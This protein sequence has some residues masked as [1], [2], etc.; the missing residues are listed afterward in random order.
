[1]ATQVPLPNRNARLSPPQKPKPRK[2][3]APPLPDGWRGSWKTKP[4]LD[5]DKWKLGKVGKGPRKGLWVAKPIPQKPAAAATTDTPAAPEVNPYTGPDAALLWQYKDQ[6]WAQNII[7]SL[8]GEQTHHEGY[9]NTQVLPWASGALTGLA[10]INKAAQ[11]QFTGATNAAA[12]GLAQAAGATPGMVAGV[13]G[14]AV[15]SPSAFLEGASAEAMANRAS[16]M[17][18]T[19]A[20]QGLMGT[21]QP[22]TFSQGYIASLSDYA[23]GLPALYAEKRREAID[24]IDKYLA[25][26]E[27]EKQKIAIEQARF[28][29]EAARH[30]EAIRHN[31]V[32]ESISATNAQTNAA[33]QFGRL[34][35]DAS[36]AAFKMQGEPGEPM[37]TS[38]PVG[39]MVVPTADGGWK[40]VRDVTVPQ[41]TNDTGGG[42]GGGGDDPSPSRGEY[43]PN[44]LKKEGF[45]RLPKGAGKRYRDAAVKA[46][47]GTLWYKPGG[48][49]GGG[50]SS[51]SG[52]KPLSAAT[53]ISELQKLYK[54]DDIGGW[55]ERYDG[56]PK[57]AGAE[58]A[59][60]IRQNKSSF[61]KPGGGRAVDLQKLNQVLRTI[62]GQPAAYAKD[63]LLRGYM[64]AD[65][66]RW[67]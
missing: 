49:S 46:T 25:E 18:Q 57:G 17:G 24:S 67:K 32:Q 12:Q 41:A 54:K 43:P 35:I 48:K 7:R 10:N 34:G 5:P 3:K 65:G 9:V 4:K 6:P 38:A 36:T 19:A 22:T 16:T 14:G 52:T 42:G 50:K 15:A 13:S 55:E 60:W 2:P 11:D 39:W 1:M 58:I 33:I 23:K 40:Y 64:T 47:D 28:E 63:I 45:K 21:L 44:K 20:W 26:V 61:V 27:L 62:G 56:D 8:R 37:P 30:D 29:L 31:K 59:L 53:L 51:G 66:T